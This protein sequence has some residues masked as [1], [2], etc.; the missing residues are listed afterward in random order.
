[1]KNEWINVANKMPELNQWCICYHGTKI[2]LVVIYKGK[3][4]WLGL[5]Y[6]CWLKDEDV[7]Y[8]MPIPE[9]PEA[10]KY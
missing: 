1:M 3:N 4:S 5:D 8:W 10:K 7:T 2:P 6:E 9:H